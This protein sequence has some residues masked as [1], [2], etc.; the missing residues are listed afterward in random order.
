MKNLTRFTLKTSFEWK[1]SKINVSLNECDYIK[2]KTLCI[3]KETINN[4]NRQ[5]PPIFL[6]PNYNLTTEDLGLGKRK[7]VFISKPDQD[8]HFIVT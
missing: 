2:L 8:R 5:P 3:A 6:L 1:E 7:I 4:V